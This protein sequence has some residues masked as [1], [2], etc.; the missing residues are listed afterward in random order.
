MPK[1]EILENELDLGGE[2]R[3]LRVA[4]SDDESI[5]L[6]FDAQPSAE[7]VDAEA[8]IYLKSQEV[9]RLQA[10]IEELRRFAASE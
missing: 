8:D 2:R 9:A 6:S 5:Y 3:T 7:R 10:E 1:Y 4:V